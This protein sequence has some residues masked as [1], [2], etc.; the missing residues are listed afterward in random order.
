MEV[1]QQFDNIT[2]HVI[3]DLR[4]TLR[5]GS[6]VTIAA[7]SFSIYAYEALQKELERVKEL[8]FIFT[9][10][11][12]NREREKKQKR[13]FYIPKLN[14][15]RTLYGS[16]FEI[17]LRNNL[18]QRA[19]AK[20]CADWIR[21]KV[22]FKT[23]ISQLTMPGFLNVDSYTYMPFNE[24]TTTEL[25]CERGNNIFQL[26]QRMPS[27]MSDSYLRYFN[28][29]WED[30]EHFAEVT[31]T[32]IENIENV[33]RE[34]SPD[35]IYFVTLYNIFHEFLEDISEDVLPNEATGF[36]SSQ[37]W[38]KLYNFQRDA[39]L[40]IIN[41]LETYNGCILAD[42]VGL[43]KT[44]TAL[45]VIKY[46]ENRNKSVLV[47]CPKKLYENWNT[48]KGNYKN[49]PLEKD[50]LR[51]DV[52]FHTDLSRER[53]MS[54]GI[55]LARLNWG[56]Y[57]LIV[58]DE[59][60]NF[61]NG[62][63]VTTDEEDENPREN[64][65]LRLMNQVIRAGVRTKV[66]M[67]S[68]TPVNNRFND[69]KNQLQLAYEGNQALI[70]DK[71][72][73]D[74]PIEDIFRAA[75]AQYNAWS[76][77][78]DPK[79]RTTERLLDMLS[80]D[81]FQVLDAVTI[82]RSRK[83]IEKYYDTTDIG[84]F[85]TRLHPIS[86]RPKLTDLDE[87]I[88]YREIADSLN[89]L[90]LGVYAPSDYILASK[91]AKYEI[92][93]DD[94]GMHLGM[95]GREKGLK[96][97]MAINLL[98]RLESS[99]NSFRLTLSRM[100]EL[101][102]GT[103]EAIDTYLENHEDWLGISL[104]AESEIE[105]T[106]G[107]MFNEDGDEEILIGGKKSRVSL[108]DMDCLSWKR[109]LEADQRILGDL[110]AMIADINPEHDSKLQMLTE[111]LREKFAN[112]IN[113][114]NKK[115]LVFTA[116]SDTAEYLYDNLAA[117][118][119]EKT[120]LHVG[121]VT[122][123][124]IRST[125]KGLPA[126]FNSILTLFSPVSKEKD[127]L[128]PKQQE[129]IDVLIATDCISEGQNLQDC[130]YLINYDIHWNPV[131][132]IQRFGRID[133]IGSKNDVI[134]LVNYWPDI[135]LDDYLYLKGRVESRMVGMNITGAGN[136]NVLLTDE[137]QADLDYRKSQLMRL[138]EEVVDLEEMDT[139]INIMDLGLNEFRLDLLA[140]L[141][142]HPD[143]EHTPFGMNAVVPASATAKPGVIYILKNRNNAVNIGHHNLLH[144]FY[145]VY[146][147]DEGETIVG[148]LAPKRLLD[149]MRAACKGKTEPIMELC[150]Q[151][152]KKT[153]NGRK[154]IHYSDLLQKAVATIVA[155]KEES[156]LE[157]LFSFGETTA[158]QG[159]I[160]GLD[161]FELI[162]FLVIR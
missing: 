110:L 29:F 10:P 62:G 162:C 77:I 74:R 54:N 44:F 70:N 78:E 156:D 157:S 3:D 128:F 68:A 140:Y 150:N 42:S 60:H 79:E 122:G 113:N 107:S 75:Q 20:E 94:R 9:S 158:L 30:K 6:K 146:L 8:R 160:R 103:L 109:D 129:V 98:K 101:V 125:I 47:L 88:T 39:A 37:I 13:E 21:R 153:D 123:N 108:A 64:R 84:K 11:T 5:N 119:Q 127:K 86:K 56:N 126:D 59:S 57:D 89:G 51:Y 72:N 46:Y 121:L 115:V 25:G 87:A 154:M 137:E 135:E 97:L 96:K 81:F 14:R 142:E 132:I 2:K 120:G 49:N 116:F 91:R 67:L 24:F 80:F 1:P 148:H 45:S 36:R 23:N 65:Y 38:N 82:A 149:I 63:K 155:Q 18:T 50:R 138:Q 130:D 22:R 134:Q 111:N 100:K 31:D 19:I 40:A 43:G 136:S 28:E 144:P 104:A 52:L 112:P 106:I 124:G 26:I 139:G 7:A 102:D 95:S 35:F 41:K 76:H 92:E 143:I 15:E 133:R 33:Y 34:N 141:H 53:G 147:S 16:D 12:F 32:V 105:E 131:R 55:D 4:T 93:T 152:N 118:I 145:M 161:D 85:P 90:N 58:I 159:D 83:H 114:D 151:F 17:R 48:Y 71:L 69:L 27:P 117:K 99:V 66:L 73:T 61:R